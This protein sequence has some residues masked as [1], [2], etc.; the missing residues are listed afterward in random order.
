MT[1]RDLLAEYILELTNRRGVV[2][3]HLSMLLQLLEV[4]KLKARWPS[5]SKEEIE[6]VAR[7][8]VREETP[9]AGRHARVRRGSG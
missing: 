9:P 7:G 3:M 8:L 2:E 4:P 5:L 6:Y 1:E